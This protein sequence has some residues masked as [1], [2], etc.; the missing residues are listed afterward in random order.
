[1]VK[2][3]F[4][5]D[6]TR[7]TVLDSLEPLANGHAAASVHCSIILG[8]SDLDLGPIDVRHHHRFMPPPIR[9]RGII[10]LTWLITTSDANS[11]NRPKLLNFR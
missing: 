3:W 7:N 9:G 4:G 2:S 5:A 8:L 1:M 6:Q 10:T 11:N